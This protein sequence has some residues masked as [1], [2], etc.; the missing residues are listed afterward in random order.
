[1]GMIEQIADD[2]AAIRKLLEAGGAPAKAETAAEKKKREAAEAKAK[3]GEAKDKPDFTAEDLRSKFLAV[4]QKHGDDEAKGLITGLGY[5]KLA[6]LIAD[7]ENWQKSMDAAVA[8][9]DEEVADD[10]GGL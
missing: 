10:N 8:K 5:G 7:T 6:E 9:L 2:V 4:Q 3:E 1:M